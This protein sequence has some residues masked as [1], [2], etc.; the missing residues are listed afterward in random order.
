MGLVKRG[1]GE[2]SFFQFKSKTTS[3]I[4]YNANDQSQN[5]DMAIT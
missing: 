4:S 3:K 1:R 5:G 2:R